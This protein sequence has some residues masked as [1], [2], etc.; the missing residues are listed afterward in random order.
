[1]LFSYHYSIRQ[2]RNLKNYSSKFNFLFFLEVKN[3]V[4]TTKLSEIEIC[5]FLRSIFFNKYGTA[6]NCELK[7]KFRPL[8]AVGKRSGV[9]VPPSEFPQG[10][11]PRPILF[12]F[13]LWG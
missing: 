4:F 11:V 6:I 8:A 1:M 13:H 5:T 7:A 3:I 12:W 2:T 10:L 9:S